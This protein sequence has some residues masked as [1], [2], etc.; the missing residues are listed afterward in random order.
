MNKLE[1]SDSVTRHYQMFKL[2]R[3]VALKTS[4]FSFVSDLFRTKQV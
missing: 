4:A 1:D 3:L 2:M